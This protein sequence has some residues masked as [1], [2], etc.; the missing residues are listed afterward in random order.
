M[1]NQQRNN[2]IEEK[3][4]TKMENVFLLDNL[5]DFLK[6]YAQAGKSLQVPLPRPKN[7][8][9]STL[10][11]DNLL[12]PGYRDIREHSNS[13]IRLHMRFEQN[14][15]C[16]FSIK[17]LDIHKNHLILAETATINHP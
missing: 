17:K 11:K 16:V 7:E 3:S 4:T 2:I 12:A 14:T 5:R 6:A 8:T 10:S 15:K 9:S 1:K 13:Q